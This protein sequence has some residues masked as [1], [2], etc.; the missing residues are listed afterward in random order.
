MSPEAGNRAGVHID[1]LD[2]SQ[3]ACPGTT[4]GDRPRTPV[5]DATALVRTNARRDDHA[6]G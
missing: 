3:S 5:E 1:R 4:G 2:L 6:A